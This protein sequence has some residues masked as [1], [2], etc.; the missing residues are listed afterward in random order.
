VPSVQIELGGVAHV[1]SPLKNVEPE[2][3]PVAL[4]SIGSGA[5]PSPSIN[6]SVTAV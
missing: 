6:P 2:A 1:L 4:K 5:V 3:V